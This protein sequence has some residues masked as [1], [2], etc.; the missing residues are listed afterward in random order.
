MANALICQF[1]GFLNKYGL[2][3]VQ[4]NFTYSLKDPQLPS[5]FVTCVQIKGVNPL[6]NSIYATV[7]SRRIFNLPDATVSRFRLDYGM[8]LPVK[9]MQ[10][11]E[12]LAPSFD[13]TEF[14]QGFPAI[15]KYL[16]YQEFQEKKISRNVFPSF[17]KWK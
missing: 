11:V 13:N 2:C 14:L 10:N 9:L 8:K 1:R 3:V 17:S 12:A 7:A 16:Q 15:S 6:P 5:L 4:P